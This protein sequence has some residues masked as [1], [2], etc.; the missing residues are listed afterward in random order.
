MKK[1]ILSVLLVLA[2]IMLVGCGGDEPQQVSD[3]Q[4]LEEVV[5]DINTEQ[6]AA[7]KEETEE[8]TEA[9]TINKEEDTET[10]SQKNAVDMAKLYL[11]TMSFSKKGLVEQLEFEGFSNEDAT[12]AVNQISVDWKEQA[13]KM[14]E[15]YLET[16]PF[17]RSSLIEQLEF[18]GFTTEEATYAVDQIGL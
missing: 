11:S 18:E 1:R 3:N 2:L 16:M 15:T 12:Y 13:V 7:S 5:S 8:T 10:L 4:G 14:A 6:E 9:V 17:S